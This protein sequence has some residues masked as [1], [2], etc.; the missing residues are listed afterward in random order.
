QVGAN[1]GQ[2]LTLS[3]SGMGSSALGISAL[4]LNNASAA[5]NVLDSAITT[6][7]S[8]RG[9][10]GAAQNRLEHT[11]ANLNVTAENLSASESRIQHQ[12]IRRA[13]RLDPMASLTVSGLGS[14]GIDVSS[15]VSQ[16][17]AIERA[18]Q[19]ALSAKKTDTL[20]RGTT[21]SSITTQLTSLQAAVQAVQTPA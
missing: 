10:F 14:S 5:I 3:T 19:D 7:S 21:W 1:A 11:I 4:S 8:Q 15:V 12:Q 16:L 9:I 6:V 2:T 20:T 18:P 13:E 17:M